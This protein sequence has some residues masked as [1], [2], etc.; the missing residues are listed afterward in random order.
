MITI[1]ERLE[2]ISH[3]INITKIKSMNKIKIMKLV[4]HKNKK[5]LIMKLFWP[6]S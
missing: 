2:V 5:R 3:E 1:N 6:V 4:I